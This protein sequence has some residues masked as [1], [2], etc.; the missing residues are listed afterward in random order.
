[1]EAKRI[2]SV[3][4][5]AGMSISHRWRPGLAACASGTPRYGRENGYTG[6]RGYAHDEA[7]FQV[8][9]DLD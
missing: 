2:V 1:M 5:L 7:V 9:F 8:G 4:A 3:L 6:F